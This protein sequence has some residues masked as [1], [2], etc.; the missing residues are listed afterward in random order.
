MLHAETGA[1]YTLVPWH[2][3]IGSWRAELAHGDGLREKEDAPYRRLR[4]VLR[5][6]LA[7]RAFG[8]LHPDWASALALSSSKTSRHLH[9]RDGGLAL[10]T[11][12]T[13]RLSEL[14]GP[15]LVV[16]GHT[17]VPRL[18]RAARGVYANAGAWY[19]DQQYLRLDADRIARMQWNKS[20]EGQVLDTFNRLAE[21]ASSKS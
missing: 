1:H 21:E 10:L 13:A 6:P 18:E 16:H 7:I 3:Y 5:N 2:G 15:D 17:H 12:G 11:A 14:N 19:I 9:A 20:S 4:T 8:W